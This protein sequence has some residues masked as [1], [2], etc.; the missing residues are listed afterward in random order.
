MVAKQMNNIFS[1]G[2]SFQSSMLKIGVAHA[3][4]CEEPCA[5]MEGM[6]QCIAFNSRAI[7]SSQTNK[8]MKICSN[9]LF[10]VSVFMTSSVVLLK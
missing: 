8:E 9:Y 5:G 7:N 3:G 4:A 6:G 10:Q 1:S 2:R